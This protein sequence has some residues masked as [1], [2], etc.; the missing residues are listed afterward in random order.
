MIT[1]F[2]IPELNN[3]DV[4]ELWFQQ[5]G[6][7]CY[8]ARATIDLLKD[9]LGDRLISRFGPVNWPP[10]SCDLTPLD[11]FLWV[12]VKS[13]VYADKTK[14][15][16]H[17]EDNI[18]R[19]IADRRPQMLE[20]VIENWT[21]RLDYIRASRGSPVPE[22]IFKIEENTASLTS[23]ASGVA[24][25][26]LGG[27]VHRGPRTLTTKQFLPSLRYKYKRTATAGSDVVQSGRPIFDD[28]FQHL[29]PYIGN[30]TANVVFQ[31]VKRLWLIRI[32]Q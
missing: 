8:T 19:V 30:N 17:L 16:D 7:T 13:L 1:N 20:K 2:F 31:M 26:R 25:N 3:H 27:A 21:S 9:T 24:T 6:A 32:D 18:R 28:F 29:R 15:L 5:D 10:R 22:I 14:T 12:Y 4:Q 11:Y 23:A